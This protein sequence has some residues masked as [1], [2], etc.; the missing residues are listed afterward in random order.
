MNTRNNKQRAGPEEVPQLETPGLTLN[1]IQDLLVKELAK[2]QKEWQK[3]LQTNKQ[4]ILEAMQ[5]V[6]NKIEQRLTVLETKIDGF[7]HNMKQLNK[8]VHSLTQTQEQQQ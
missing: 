6:E 2:G 1:A 3:S 4:E 7:E 5:K 8:K